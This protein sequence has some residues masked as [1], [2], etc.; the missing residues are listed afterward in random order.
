MAECKWFHG[1]KGLAETKGIREDVF[2]TEQGI[3][4]E[5]EF[6]RADEISTHL[7]V[8]D[9]ERAVATGRFYIEDGCGYLGRIAVL[10]E[11]RK[12]GYG[13][14]V[15]TEMMR[16]ALDEGAERLEIHAQLHAVPFYEKCGFTAI[17]EAYMLDGLMHLTMVTE[18]K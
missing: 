3:D 8:Y 7:V 17:G 4:A 14:V 18:K 10:R 11:C 12:H 1:L 6:D 5:A 2:I 9:R 16:R 13:A 15:V